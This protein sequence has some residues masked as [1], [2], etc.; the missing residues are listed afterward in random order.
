[1][2]PQACSFLPRKDYNAEVVSLTAMRHCHNNVTRDL[3]TR[4]R[5]DEGL[6]QR[7]LGKEERVQPVTPRCSEGSR[8][9]ARL[10]I[11]V[12]VRKRPKKV[13]VVFKRS[14][15]SRKNPF[16]E[17]LSRR[18]EASR[19][20]SRTYFQKE[21]ATFSRGSERR[22]FGRREKLSGVANLQ[23]RIGPENRKTHCDL[24]FG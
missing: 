9:I 14:S 18:K 8:A 19:E 7:E 2:G 12:V 21:E 5:D 23:R 17:G 6:G 22:R 11:D 24:C 4:R 10:E 13:K 20:R 3:N 1:M 15:S 16:G